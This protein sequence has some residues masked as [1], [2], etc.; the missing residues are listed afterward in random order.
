MRSEAARAAARGTREPSKSSVASSSRR[1]P[2]AAGLELDAI[3]KRLVRSIRRFSEEVAGW[4]G[5]I[6]VGA[7]RWARMVLFG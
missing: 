3:I 2:L 7:F 6:G 4:R 1:L 5:P